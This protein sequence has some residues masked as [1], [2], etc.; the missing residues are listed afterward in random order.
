MTG[1]VSG[2][3]WRVRD[4]GLADH[5]S[6]LALAR[7]FWAEDGFGD[8]TAQ[9][10]AVAT[11]LTSREYGVILILEPADGAGRAAGYAALCWGYSIEFG[12]RDAFLDEIYVAPEVRGQGLGAWFIEQ[13]CGRLA[14]EGVHALHLEVLDNNARVAKLYDR[15]RFEKRGRMMSRRLGA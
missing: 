12:G 11:L 1:P 4:A 13:V 6:V 5:D 3:G 2:T 7:A 10:R 9:H 8:T 14:V 15:C